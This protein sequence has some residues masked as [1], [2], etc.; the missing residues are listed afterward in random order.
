MEGVSTIEEKKMKRRYAT[1]LV[2]LAAAL[3]L[4]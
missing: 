2:T 3:I 4:A 1:L